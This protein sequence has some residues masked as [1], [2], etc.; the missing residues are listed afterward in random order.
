MGR[1]NIIPGPRVRRCHSCIAGYIRV[2]FFSPSLFLFPLFK[3][4][5]QEQ[6]TCIVT[7][8]GHVTQC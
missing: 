8:G 5:A 7:P 2:I 4:N 1:N 6:L 3:H